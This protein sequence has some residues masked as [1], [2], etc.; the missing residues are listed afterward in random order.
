MLIFL[1]VWPNFIRIWI[2][3]ATIKFPWF[4]EWCKQMTMHEHDLVL[5]YLH[6]KICTVKKTAHFPDTF[7]RNF[8]HMLAIKIEISH[9]LKGF[10][11]WYFH[12]ICWH[13][14]NKVDQ[15]IPSKWIIY[16]MHWIDEIDEIDFGIETGLFSSFCRCSYIHT[17]RTSLKRCWP[18]DAIETETLEFG[19]S[20]MLSCINIS[21]AVISLTNIPYGYFQFMNRNV[22]GSD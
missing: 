10:K 18:F 1:S 20:I 7:D 4:P 3:S 6:W 12:H 15:S 11:S 2:D 17:I 13:H 16:L 5:F 8:L 14:V 19:I 22:F 21:L 9:A